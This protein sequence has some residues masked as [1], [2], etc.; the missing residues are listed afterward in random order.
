MNETIT[1]EQIE[2]ASYQTLIS[3]CPK[4]GVKYEYQK[5]GPLR[6]L[7]IKKLDEKGGQKVSEIEN[8]N[9]KEQKKK[10]GTKVLKIIDNT[11]LSK[12]DKMRSLFNLGIQSPAE[13]SS[14]TDSHYS[15][16]FTVI[17]KYKKEG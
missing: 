3:F 10:Y 16:V 15:Y 11:D 14:L 6:E 1:K 2:E 4:M 7:L 5:K 12:A 9:K 17:S 8:P 13:I